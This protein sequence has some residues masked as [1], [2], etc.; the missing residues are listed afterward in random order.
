MGARPDESELARLFWDRLRV[1]A[2]RRLGDAV[3]AEDVAQE[4][5]RRV[6]QSVRADR[7]RSPEALPAFVFQTARNICL[8]RHRSAYRE[9]RAMSRLGGATAEPSTTSD[10]L[11]DLITEE[12]RRV[13]RAALTRLD[14]EDRTLLQLFFY[15]GSGTA[16]VAER[17]GATPGAIRVR[18]HR[19]L[20]RLSELLQGQ[21]S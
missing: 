7:L 20:R 8:Q 1:F 21:G 17:L 18:K 4:T 13:V 16:E 14:S 6:V 5:L 10:P 2:A 9:S 3:A 19:A 11:L 12:R 15:E